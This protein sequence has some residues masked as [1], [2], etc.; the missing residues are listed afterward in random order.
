MQ[1]T[2]GKAWFVATISAG[3]EEALE[4]RA[5]CVPGHSEDSTD[6]RWHVQANSEFLS[7]ANRSYTLFHSPGGGTHPPCRG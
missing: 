6:K 4:I 1:S 2:S 3:S 5:S 7:T